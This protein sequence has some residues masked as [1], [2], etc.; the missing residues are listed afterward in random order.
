MICGYWSGRARS[1]SA[2]RLVQPKICVYFDRPFRLF[3]HTF[4]SDFLI[5]RDATPLLLSNVRGVDDAPDFGGP[6]G[7]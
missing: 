3:H 7:A 5:A 6:V 1:T 4:F 2:A